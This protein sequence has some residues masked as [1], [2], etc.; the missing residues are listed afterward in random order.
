MFGLNFIV[1]LLMFGKVTNTMLTL[2]NYIVLYIIHELIISFLNP[3]LFRLFVGGNFDVLSK[4]S[5]P[6]MNRSTFTIGYGYDHHTQPRISQQRHGAVSQFRGIAC[7]LLNVLLR[8]MS[9]CSSPRLRNVD[10]QEPPTGASEKQ[11]ACQ[12]SSTFES[13]TFMVSCSVQQYNS[14]HQANSS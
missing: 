1:M 11:A 3:V 12:C 14:S 10:P 2:Y 8:R 13:I 9:N 7:P 5:P 4:A 6:I